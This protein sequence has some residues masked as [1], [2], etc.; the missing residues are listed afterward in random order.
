[1]DGVHSVHSNGNTTIDGC[2][3][4]NPEWV[5]VNQV[6]L[7]RFARSS[8]FLPAVRRSYRNDVA[9][10]WQSSMS[11]PL[12]C[13]SWINESAPNHDVSLRLARLQ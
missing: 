4:S 6:H 1:M 12:H 8:V 13:P 9:Q 5:Y 7:E 2:R 3:R 10:P 11:E